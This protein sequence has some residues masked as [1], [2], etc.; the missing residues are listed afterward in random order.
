MT[1][2]GSLNLRKRNFIPTLPTEIWTETYKNYMVQ[3]CHQEAKSGKYPPE[4]IISKSEIL[5][6]TA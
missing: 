2:N 4:E 3:H 6:E 1:R 5:G